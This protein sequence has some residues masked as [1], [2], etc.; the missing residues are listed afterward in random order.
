MF[1]A[2]VVVP[3]PPFGLKQATMC[4][5]PPA[6]GSPPGRG[7][8]SRERRKRMRSP[9]TRASS[10]RGSNGLAITSSA[11]ASRKRTRSSTSSS[12]EMQ[13]TG[14]PARAGVRR[15]SA[16]TSTAVRGGSTMSIATSSKSPA[17]RIASAES[18]TVV[19]SW[20]AARSAPATGPAA[21]AT[22]ERRRMEVV[23]T[24]CGSPGFGA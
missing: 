3:T 6:E 19:T 2:I 17:R 21:S 9:S 23:D 22:A 13:R 1:T 4:R 5:R 11:P 10:S 24:W 16:Q 20:P 15:I 8:R 14:T 7:A 18:A 12:W